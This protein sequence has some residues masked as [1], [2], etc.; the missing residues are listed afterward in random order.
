MRGRG[1]GYKAPWYGPIQGF[2][3][4][5]YSSNDRPCADRHRAEGR[6]LEGAFRGGCI[7]LYKPLGLYSHVNGLGVRIEGG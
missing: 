5:L 6:P 3:C 1:K 4:L 7:A 2:P